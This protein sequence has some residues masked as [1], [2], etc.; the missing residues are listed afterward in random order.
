MTTPGDTGQRA[1]QR[2]EAGAEGGAE[3]GPQGGALSQEPAASGQGRLPAQSG[4]RPR[5]LSRSADPQAESLVLD[6]V[7]DVFVMRLLLEETGETF[8]VPNCRG[9]MTVRELKE[10]LDLIA[11]VPLN[12]LQLHYLDQGVMMDDS[13][14]NFHDVVPRGIISL[15]VWH[16]DGWTD[17]VSA[18]VEGDTSKLAC[19]GVVED[20]PYQ[21]ANSQYLGEKHWRTWVAQRAFVALYIASHR[22]RVEAVQYLL[23][24]G[25]NCL[26]RSPM[27]RTPLH[28]AV[29]MGQSDCISLLLKFGASILAKDAK[30]M[31]PQAIARQLNHR[32][33]ERQMFL[34]YWMT[35]SERKDPKD[36][37][38]TKALPS[39]KSGPGSDSG[40]DSGSTQ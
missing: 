26:G 31:S 39:R 13:T 32:R 15:C 5:T 10:E 25:A 27:G 3:A 35:K 11:G 34:S 2:A 4:A 6:E 17:L 36:S 28:V 14:L 7:P 8:E 18:A 9:D 21:T 24:H 33:D 1:M 29:A 40:S 38:E 37:G 22:G 12:L 30:G 20:S 19:L 23:E 16:Y